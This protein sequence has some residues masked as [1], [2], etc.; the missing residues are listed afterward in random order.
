MSCPFIG[1]NLISQVKKRIIKPLEGVIPQDSYNCISNINAFGLSS[2]LN[3][4]F[5]VLTE[6]YKS[7]SGNE[8]TITKTVFIKSRVAYKLELLEDLKDAILIC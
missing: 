5:V 8:Y 4:M 2:H 1:F 3:T 6:Y 7:C